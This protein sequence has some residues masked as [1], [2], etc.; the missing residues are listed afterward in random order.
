MNTMCVNC[1]GKGHRYHSCPY[2]ICSKCDEPGHTYIT[3]PNELKYNE[4]SMES[5]EINR[6]KK[7]I[8]QKFISKLKRK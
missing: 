3:C 2:V 5:I 4:E 7:S 8:Y 6:N 1:Y